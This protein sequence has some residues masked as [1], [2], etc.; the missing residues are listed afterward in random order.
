MASLKVQLEFGMEEA[1]W[2]EIYYTAGSQ[3]KAGRAVAEAMARERLKFLVNAGRIHHIRISGAQ[4]GD[5]SYRF[6]LPNGA[7]AYPIVD[8]RDNGNVT[9]TMGVYS[10]SGVFRK[11]KF[12]GLPDSS[13]YFD[14]NGVENTTVTAALGNFVDYLILNQWQIR[15]IATAANLATK[16]ISNI[17]VAS[18]G[19]VTFTVDTVG[20]VVGQKVRVSSCQGYHAS[21]FNGVWTVGGPIP[22]P[23][24]SF[25][26]SSRRFIDPNF[27]YVPSS[28]SVRD[29]SSTG[30]TYVPMASRDDFQQSGTRKTG[31]PT[32]SRRGRVSAR[33]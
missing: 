6:P 1:N 19:V 33:R 30:Y 10:T 4:P 14:A 16:K 5:R 25:A 15:H 21:Q 11:L 31:R 28:G 18:N 12:H 29:G 23:A 26:A 32:D 24:G 2:S 7:G 17:T 20:L 22:L 8:T 27:F 3:P 9:V 13:V